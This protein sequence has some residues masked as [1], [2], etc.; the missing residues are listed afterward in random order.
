M[1]THTPASA[2][3][4]TITGLVSLV[5]GLLMLAGRPGFLATPTLTGHGVAWLLLMVFGAGFSLVFGLIYR[6]IPEAFGA[7]LYSPQF[8]L[9]HYAFHL[10]GTVLVMAAAVWP[11]FTRGEMGTTLVMAGAIVCGVCLLGTFSRPARPD[12]ASAHLAAAVLW[13]I[14]AAFLGVPFVS[15][16]ALA[17]LPEAA[18]PAGWLVLALA[19]VLLNVAMGLSL[20]TAPAA[21]GNAG[22]APGMGWYALFLGN[23]GLAWAFPAIVF[24]TYGFLFLC[25]AL[26]IIAIFLHY[27]AFEKI[28]AGAHGKDAGW[29]SRILLASWT[30]APVAVGFL[31][32]SA[33]SRLHA[34]V[35]DQAAAGPAP[36][37]ERTGLLPLEFVPSDGAAVLSMLLGAAIPALVA[38]AFQLV[39][40]AHAGEEG[41]RPRLSEQILLA[42]YFNYAAGVLLLV[43]GAWLAVEK[44]LG[45]GSLFLLVGAA[46]FL[47]NYIYAGGAEDTGQLTEAE[48]RART[49]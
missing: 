23:M 27:V 46:G 35:L 48:P 49:A 3:A 24:Q 28:L 12:L 4:F 1:K 7:R 47:G 34:P 29:E 36:A 8:V 43:P 25:G 20:R 22:E 10:T 19:G 11:D 37:E 2:H 6:A 21:S 42:S 41:L 14:L 26:Y 40:K 16:P 5:M 38:L 45:L 17:F 9:L 39:R 13:L 18:W 30:L 44:M 31:L 32:L 33:W 15:K